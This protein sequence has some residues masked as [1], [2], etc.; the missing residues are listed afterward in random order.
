MAVA[1]REPS[2]PI[3]EARGLGLTFQTGDGP[4][5]ALV[6]LWGPSRQGSSGQAK[7]SSPWYCSNWAWA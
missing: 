3:I 6:P 1:M 5:Q 7:A 2:I 4:V